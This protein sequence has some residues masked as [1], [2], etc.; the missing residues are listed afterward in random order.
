MRL[1][2]WILMK[3]CTI[4]RNGKQS[5]MNSDSISIAGFVQNFSRLMY[6]PAPSW[7]SSAYWEG[8]VWIMAEILSSARS[9][10]LSNRNGGK[11][12]F[13]LRRPVTGFSNLV[14]FHLSVCALWNSFSSLALPSMRS[15]LEWLDDD[16]HC[17]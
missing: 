7:K 5:S 14:R 17:G 11:Y 1:Y 12:R 2:F 13:L 3:V 4:R 9:H 6:A 8:N 16:E 10:H 15:E